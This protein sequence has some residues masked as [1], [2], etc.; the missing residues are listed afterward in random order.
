MK[1]IYSGKRYTEVYLEYIDQ[2]INLQRILITGML[3][4]SAII[5]MYVDVKEITKI[6]KKNIIIRLALVISS[7]V[8]MIHLNVLLYSL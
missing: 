8:H 3:Y 6:T 5:T 4:Y 7:N 2:W 1:Q